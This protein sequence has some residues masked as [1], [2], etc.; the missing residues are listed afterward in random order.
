LRIPR[1]PEPLQQ[2]LSSVVAR[3]F[4][5]RSDAAELT[6]QADELAVALVGTTTLRTA[7]Y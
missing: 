6:K 4:T 1:P 3:E 2:E 5:L 7:R